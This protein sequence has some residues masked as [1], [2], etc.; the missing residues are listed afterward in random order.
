MIEDIQTSINFQAL[1]DVVTIVPLWPKYYQ[2]MVF[3]ANHHIRKIKI[4]SLNT[5]AIDKPTDPTDALLLAYYNDYIEDYQIPEK[6]LAKY[7][8]LSVQDWNVNVG[9]EDVIIQK[10]Y[11]ENLSNFIE[12]ESR[13]VLSY[14]FE[15]ESDALVFLEKRSEENNL[16]GVSMI[17]LGKVTKDG[18]PGDSSVQIFS[19]Q[20]GSYTQPIDTGV[21]WFVFYVKA[22]QEA[23]PKSFDE[24]KD[25]I[26][27]QLIQSKKEKL[28]EERLIEIEDFIASGATMQELVE[29]FDLTLKNQ[30][31]SKRDMPKMTLDSPQAERFKELVF[32]TADEET[33]YMDQLS[34]KGL[35]VIYSLDQIFASR[36]QAFDEVKGKLTE[37]WK[38][39]QHKINLQQALNQWLENDKAPQKNTVQPASKVLFVSVNDADNILDDYGASFKEA[40]FQ[41]NKGQST[42]VFTSDK[43]VFAAQL[44]EITLP[45]VN[46]QSN[47]LAY[48]QSYQQDMKMSYFSY[49]QS[50]YPVKVN[51]SLFNQ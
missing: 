3:K 25:L 41:I 34:N 42:Q 18:L 31:F 4:F 35:F 15:N 2:E 10:Y 16:S 23:R 39:Y 27:A 32:Q 6:R 45:D 20:K 21:G 8:L 19:I 7:A 22:I 43:A 51:E 26:K 36:T 48:E 47:L 50:I 9:I 30:S 12:A 49:L 13:H 46:Q 40:I 24:V 1:E 11:Q 38:R 37:D 28:F 44:L 14:N 17:D 29:R 5:E 33:L